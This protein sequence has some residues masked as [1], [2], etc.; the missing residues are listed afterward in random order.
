M[1]HVPIDARPA[2]RS[3]R[4]WRQQAV[5]TARAKNSAFTLV[6]LLVVIAALGILMALLIPVVGSARDAM[7]R[8][9]CK[10]NLKQIGEACQGHVTKL[11]YFPSSGWG[12]MW[13]GDPDHGFGATQ[14]GGW[15]YNILPFLGLDKIHDVGKGVFDNPNNPNFITTGGAKEIALSE[16]QSAVIPFLICPVRRKAIGYPVSSTYPW[17]STQPSSAMISKTDYAANSGYIPLDGLW[18]GPPFN[19]N[20]YTTFT[21]WASARPDLLSFTGIS[22]ERSQIAPGNV[23]NGL[24]NV[25]L[26]G[27]KF[28]NPANYSTGS[29][30]LD[31][32][33]ALTGMGANTNRFT[34]NPLT[35]DVSGLVNDPPGFG[36]AHSQGAHFVFCDGSVKMISYTIDPATYQNMGS[37]NSGTVSESN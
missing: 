10:N 37:R 36:S 21:T 20:P 2:A 15:I 11:G 22:G 26:A 31:N 29:D 14:P 1:P 17:N 30:P 13:T 19:S 27:E 25:F 12:Y 16:A 6:E 34:Y 9:Q 4:L 24:S 5:A 7:R 32:T 3:L 33:T 18:T 28:L 23:V 8:M 35:R